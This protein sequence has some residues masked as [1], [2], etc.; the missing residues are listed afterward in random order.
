MTRFFDNKPTNLPEPENFKA[1]EVYAFFGLCSYFAQI[2]EQGLINLVVSL[3]IS[4]LTQLTQSDIDNLFSKTGKRTLGQLIKDVNQQIKI[5]DDLE[6]K[7]STAVNNRNYIV[8]KFF[9][10]HDID[11]L[12]ESGRSKMIVELKDITSMFQQVDYEL[13][14]ITHSL[15]RK[16]GLTEEMIKNEL[17]IMKKEAKNQD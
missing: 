10:T 1:K 11:F 8:H 7:L 9:T 17:E 5:S 3:Q 12:S 4:N 2:L 16:L 13:E 15:Y 14:F 6:Y